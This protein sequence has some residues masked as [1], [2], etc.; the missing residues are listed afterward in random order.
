MPVVGIVE[1]WQITTACLLFATAYRPYDTV[2]LGNDTLCR[3]W[4]VKY[5]SSVDGFGQICYS[6]AG[7]LLYMAISVSLSLALVVISLYV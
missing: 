1:P 4:R 2:R 5:R 7:P 6:R 3:F